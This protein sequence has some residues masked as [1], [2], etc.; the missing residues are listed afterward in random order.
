MH[1]HQIRPVLNYTSLILRISVILLTISTISGC[2]LNL[3]RE[4]GNSLDK[5]VGRGPV[6]IAPNDTKLAATVFFRNSWSAS[7][8]IKHLITQRGTP[9]A[10]SLERDFLHP[11]RLRL[12]YP[13]D[14]Q[15]YL[16]DYVSGEWLIA[17]SEPISLEEL[18]MVRLQRDQIRATPIRLGGD[19]EPR[20]RDVDVTPGELNATILEPHPRL[21]S[22]GGELRGMLKARG[23]ARVAKL[24]QGRGGLGTYIHTVSFPG[25]TFALLADWYLEDDALARTLA[26]LNHGLLAAELKPGE[27]VVIPAKL[28]RNTDPL[29]EAMVSRF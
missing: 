20:P 24:E 16:L 29:P 27:E 7:A 25:E 18:D 5:L 9:E 19:S 2:S 28:I 4:D 11:N 1:P 14:G 6:I 3:R 17:G 22:K 8:S 13:S 12:Y 10:L 21:A 23:A 26:E 15:V